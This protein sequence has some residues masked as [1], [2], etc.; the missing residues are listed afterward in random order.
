MYNNTRLNLSDWIP[1]Y[2]IEINKTHKIYIKY[3]KTV[4]MAHVITYVGVP[5]ENRYYN[6]ITYNYE[7][8]VNIVVI[9]LLWKHILT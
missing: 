2:F 1:L 3:D 6:V 5:F 8:P 4:Y 9:I 7:L